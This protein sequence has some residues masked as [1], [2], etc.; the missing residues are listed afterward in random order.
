MND[1]WGI[2]CPCMNSIYVDTL[3]ECWLRLLRKT[4]VFSKKLS[5]VEI[6]LQVGRIWMI[7]NQ[8]KIFIG[9]IKFCLICEIFALIRSSKVMHIHTKISTKSI[10]SNFLHLSTCFSYTLW[11][12]CVL[13]YPCL[14]I[15]WNLRKMVYRFE[16]N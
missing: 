14:I 3:N 16:N 7:V 12:I 13:F 15:K 6:K 10:F 9:A 5:T 1:L 2:F 8:N 4:L 11:D